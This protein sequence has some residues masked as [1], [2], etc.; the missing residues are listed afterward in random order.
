MNADLFHPPVCCLR[1]GGQYNGGFFRG[2]QAFTSLQA[3]RIYDSDV[4]LVINMLLELECSRINSANIWSV[5]V[6]YSKHNTLLQR[7]I[8]D[9]LLKSPQLWRT[10]I[11]INEDGKR[12]WSSGNDFIKLRGSEKLKIVIMGLLSQQPTSWSSMII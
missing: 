6:Y 1:S 7:K 4:Q 5:A 11:S 9:S 12:S 3:Q 10:G 8:V 2:K